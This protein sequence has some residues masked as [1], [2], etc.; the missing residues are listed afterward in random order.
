MRLI[1]TYADIQDLQFS[2]A[3]KKPLS[4]KCCQMQEPFEVV[5]MEGKM[6]GRKGDYLMIGIEGEMYVCKKSIFEKT[7]TIK[8]GK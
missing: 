1:S 7:Y 4:I 8:K 6:R 3:V 5:T 2:I